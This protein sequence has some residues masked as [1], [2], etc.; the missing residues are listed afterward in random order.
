MDQCL[1]PEERI[2]KQSDFS[3]LYK[4]GR[5]YRGRY[6]NLIFLPNALDHSRMAV[7]VS[8]KVG[9]AVARNRIKRRVRDVYRRNKGLFKEALD[10]LVVARPEIATLGGPELR[11]EYIQAVG[12]LP[13]GK[14]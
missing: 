13:S 14:K 4:N 5:R 8:R 9:N 1:R 11:S 12:S 6:F 2:R 3:F 10:L 7:V